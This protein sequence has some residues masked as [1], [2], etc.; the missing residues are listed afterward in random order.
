M[1]IL[2]KE[3][4]I[5]PEDLFDRSEW[6]ADADASWWALYTKSRQEKKL[7]RQLLAMQI[8]FYC[9]MVPRRSRGQAGRKQVAYIPLLSGYVF[10]F[11]DHDCRRVA[12]TT[13]C[14]SQSLRV[15]DTQQ[16]VHDLNQIRQLIESGVPITPEDRLQQGMAVRVRNGPFSGIDG[17]VCKRHSQSRL[18]VGLRFLQQGVSVLLEDYQ[19]EPI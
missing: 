15:T 9:P 5:Y 19:C 4:S 13:N 1:T 12:L 11:G 8:P 16:F 10:L 6:D 14:V 18:V 2:A 17:V 3:A 7:M